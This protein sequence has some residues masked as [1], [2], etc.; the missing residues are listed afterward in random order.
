MVEPAAH[1]K[2]EVRLRELA[3]L[4]NVMDPSPFIDRDLDDAAEEFIVSWAR[5]L[6][7]G[8]ELELVIHVEVP[9]LPDRREGLAKAVHGYFKGRAEL[10]Q[11]EFRQLLKRGRTSLIIGL[12]F[13]AACF[14]ASEAVAT[15]GFGTAAEFIQES[16]LIGGWVAMWRPLEIFLYDW[17]P[18]RSER[19]LYRRLAR[20][21]VKLKVKGE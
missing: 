9:P 14:A 18:V 11:H 10:K 13:L 12:L 15:L 5:E 17:W 7:G 8:K 1:G 19:E 3:Q 20:M 21:G 2:I 4:F 6:P 16:L